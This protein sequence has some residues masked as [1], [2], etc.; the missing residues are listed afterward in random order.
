MYHAPVTAGYH[1]SVWAKIGRTINP[2]ILRYA[3]FLN[4]PVSAIQK[5]WSR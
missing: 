2:L 3:P 1:Q 4:T 5:W